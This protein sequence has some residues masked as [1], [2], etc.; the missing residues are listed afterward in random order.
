MY[1]SS[2]NRS[3]LLAD[4]SRSE[5]TNGHSNGQANGRFN[6]DHLPASGSGAGGPAGKEKGI[7]KTWSIKK[8][9]VVGFSS[10]VAILIIFAVACY[11]VVGTLSVEINDITTN[12]LP[13]VVNLAQIDADMKEARRSLLENMLT[14]DPVELKNNSDLY[15]Q[16]VANAQK[17]IQD[18]ESSVSHPPEPDEG[19]LYARTVAT[20]NSLK[21]N[22][23]QVNQLAVAGKA[24]EA[25]ALFTANNGGADAAFAAAVKEELDFNTK[26]ANEVSTRANSLGG[27]TKISIMA[28]LGVALVLSFV[29]SYWII[30]SIIRPLSAVLKLAIGISNGDF[31]QDYQVTGT[32]EVAQVGASLKGTMKALLEQKVAELN[33]SR[34]V[35]VM[36]RTQAT[37]EFT[38]E[39]TVIAANEI[40]LSTMGY[41][42]EEIQGRNHSLF[43][44]PAYRDTPEYRQFWRDLNDGKFQTAEFKRI[45][46]KGQEVWLQATYSPS[47]DLDGKVSKVTK[48]ALD[49]TARK[50]AEASLK[51][52]LDIVMQN[53]QAL[54]SASEELSATSQQ[55]V[56]NA[57]ETATQASVVSAAAEQVSKNVQTVASGTNEMSASI[58]EIAKNAQEAAKVATSAVKAAETTNTTITKL[59]E[60]SAEI[61][62]VIK[63]ITSIAQQTNLLALNATIEAA[64]AGEAGKGFAVVANDSR[65]RCR[66]KSTSA[67][68]IIVRTMA[69]K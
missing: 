16:S 59:G 31:K 67:C 58:R 17:A 33:T 69:R 61:G 26:Y 25:Y 47:F 7:R 64:R 55:M 14:S 23:D 34:Q 19:P 52:T 6:L 21:S 22:S 50:V 1:N 60:S 53:S 30:L 9:I 27:T 46:K 48:C 32:D 63:V 38:H 62:K 68:R 11:F 4:D 49:I 44:D 56:G 42:L 43:V 18:Y 10:L 57:E 5:P 3:A 66:L 29:I 35:D 15:A 28:G 2:S 51:K 39:G 41:R 12:W 8:R 45:N 40:F 54:S 36:N 20:F 37:V 13:G 65:D 24:K